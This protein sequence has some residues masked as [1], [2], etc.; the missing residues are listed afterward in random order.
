MGFRCFTF[1]H[2][3]CSGGPKTT[4]PIGIQVNPLIDS[5]GG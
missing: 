4:E 1:N 3:A 5:A 2:F